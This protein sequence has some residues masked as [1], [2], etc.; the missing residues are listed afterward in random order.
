[1]TNQTE[2]K[3]PTKKYIV[4]MKHTLNYKVGQMVELTDKKAKSLSGKIRLKSE[5]DNES[6]SQNTVM[7]LTSANE[8]L[9]KENSEMK[10][11]ISTLEKAA[12]KAAK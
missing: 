9:A 4:E 12:K 1:M 2:K 8:A 3:A 6:E 11:K 10:D 5:L 7:E